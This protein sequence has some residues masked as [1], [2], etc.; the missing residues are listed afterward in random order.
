M[1]V[2]RILL[3]LIVVQQAFG[4]LLKVPIQPQQYSSPTWR[5]FRLC[6]RPP[7]VEHLEICWSIL[8]ISN[9]ADVSHQFSHHE[10]FQTASFMSDRTR[11]NISIL[12]MSYCGLN[13]VYRQSRS[14]TGIQ[15]PFSL[16]SIYQHTLLNMLFHPAKY[17]ANLVQFQ[18]VQQ[19][20]NYRPL[21]D[22]QV[23]PE[24]R[25]VTSRLFSNSLLSCLPSNSQ[26][27]FIADRTSEIPA[28][29]SD[30]L[31][32]IHPSIETVTVD[33]GVLTMWLD[34]HLVQCHLRRARLSMLRSFQPLIPFINN[35]KVDRSVR[36]KVLVDCLQSVSDRAYLRYFK[37]NSRRIV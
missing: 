2:I 18:V 14:T 31:P 32:K 29:S 36:D 28:A 34:G 5:I 19:T 6:L 7:S 20:I 1:T 26:F 11:W 9:I 27:S 17:D 35:L 16:Q 37:D 12:V 21:N 22:V 8:R 15:H 4:S 3:L 23:N 33:Y 10:I 24:K 30:S 13:S 25:I